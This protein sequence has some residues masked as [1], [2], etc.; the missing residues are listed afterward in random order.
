L[1]HNALERRILMKRAS[2]AGVTALALIAGSSFAQNDNQVYVRVIH[3]VP[4]VPAATVNIGQTPLFS[5]VAFKQITS[6]KTLPEQDDKTVKITLADGRQL[7]TTEEFSFDDANSQYTI[8]IAPGKAGANPIVANLKSDKEKIDTDETELN[9][10]NA[11]PDHKALKL[12]VNDKTLERGVDFAESGDDDVDPG[13]YNL[14]V[15]DTAN[16][17]PVASRAVSLAGGTGVS[18]VVYADGA[19]R[20]VNDASPNTDLGGGAA[21]T[22]AGTMQTSGTSPSRTTDNMTSPSM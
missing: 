3:A 9:L 7:Q 14:K 1:R 19:V 20:V 8:L 18:V 6:F 21:E 2:I 11:A 17:T 4:G 13:S 16:N 10:I 15:V 12:M 22:T 5:D